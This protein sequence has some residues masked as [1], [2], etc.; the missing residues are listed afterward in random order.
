M[1]M[2]AT[3]RKSIAA[4]I[5]TCWRRNQILLDGKSAEPDNDGT[6]FLYSLFLYRCYY[7]VCN[8]ISCC[9]SL[10]KSSFEIIFI[11]FLFLSL[12]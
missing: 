8:E 4:A 3:A 7:S 10:Y 5:G 12:L 6:S 1:A 11:L 9:C 2:A